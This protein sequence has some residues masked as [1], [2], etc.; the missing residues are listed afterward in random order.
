LFDLADAALCADGPV[1]SLLAL[2]LV[3][4]HLWGHGALYDVL[5]TGRVDVARLRAAVASM[6][7]PRAAD[8]RTVLA[9]DVT[10]WPV[11]PGSPKADFRM[12]LTTRSSEPGTLAVRLCLYP[13]WRP[14]GIAKTIRFQ[15]AC[16]RY[17]RGCHDART[18]HRSGRSDEPMDYHHSSVRYVGSV[19][20]TRMVNVWQA[21]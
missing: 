2:S 16:G 18:T 19:D 10:C 9:V 1:Y 3:V 13:W 15:P 11:E 14:G 20:Y 6:V 8:G 4:E 17:D 12:I 5:G 7:V 21:L